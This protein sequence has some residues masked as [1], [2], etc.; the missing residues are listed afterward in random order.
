MLYVSKGLL[1]TSEN[2]IEGMYRTIIV[3]ACVFVGDISTRTLIAIIY[4]CMIVVQPKNR[5]DDAFLLRERYTFRGH[6]HNKENNKII[7]AVHYNRNEPSTLLLY[8][9]C[10]D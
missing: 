6:H 9:Y 7:G 1:D 8:Y 3:C 10:A 4:Y 5:T 2:K